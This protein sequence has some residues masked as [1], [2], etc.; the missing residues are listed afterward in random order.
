VLDLTAGTDGYTR[1]CTVLTAFAESDFKS[2]AVQRNSRGVF[3]Q[4]L[5]WWPTATGTTTEQCMAFLAEFARI[6]RTGDPV[7]D[8]WQV[9]QWLAPNPATD[10][11]AF[12]AAPETVNYLRRLPLVPAIIQ[13][14]RLP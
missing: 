6:K 2:D 4:T 11:T 12:R 3:Q 14:R 8:C 7:T 5:P 9:Q 1:L 13:N 10:P